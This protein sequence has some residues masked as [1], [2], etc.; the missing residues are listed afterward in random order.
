MFIGNGR[1]FNVWLCPI[2]EGMVSRK[3]GRSQSLHFDFVGSGQCFL[4]L[5]QNTVSPEQLA[6]RIQLLENIYQ[7]GNYIEAVIWGLFAGGFLINAKLKR[8][9]SRRNS[10]MG[11]VVFF[12]FGL[13][14]LVEVETGA[15]WRPW[16]L[17]IWKASCVLGMLIL[18]LLYLRDHSLSDRL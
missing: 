3:L 10:L 6:A 12:L 5:A 14:D 15:W 18:L 11:T 4:L 13:S 8:K 17:F 2:L 16:W 1:Y 7:Y 9:E